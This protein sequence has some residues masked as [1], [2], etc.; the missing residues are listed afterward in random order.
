MTTIT[1]ES[2]DH[3]QNRITS[4]NNTITADEPAGAG[5]DD[6][7]FDPYSLLLAALGA[8]K[9]MTLKLYAKHKNWDLQ[10]VRVT[11]SHEKLHAKDCVDCETK[12]VKLDTIKVKL[13]LEGNLSDEQKS[14]L[15]EIAKRCP[16]HR[17]LTSEIRIVDE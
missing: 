12:D 2:L 8:C 3:L 6:L 17:T 7:G 4:G 14:R 13:D 16:I 1:V 5:G 10:K 15:K 11:L 9:S